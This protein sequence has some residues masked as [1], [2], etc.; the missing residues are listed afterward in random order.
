MAPRMVPPGGVPS[1]TAQALR[2]LWVDDPC[3]VEWDAPRRPPSPLPL[4]RTR[5]TRPRP[6][7]SPLDGTGDQPIRE[8]EPGAIDEPDD[9]P[10][11]GHQLT[12]CPLAPG[13]RGSGDPASRCAQ[14]SPSWSR[15]SAWRRRTGASLLPCCAAPIIASLRKDSRVMLT[16]ADGEIMDLLAVA[17]RLLLHRLR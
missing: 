11:E 7:R 10:D 13:R 4:R 5:S 3:R 15:W 9:A 16:S 1:G 6:A 17:R 12:L 2:R 8:R 14:P